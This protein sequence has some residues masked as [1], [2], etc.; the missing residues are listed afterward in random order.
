MTFTF[1][2]ETIELNNSNT[3]LKCRSKG[4]IVEV[5]ELLE[6][7]KNRQP[8]KVG[9]R[10]SVK[11]DCMASQDGTYVHIGCLKEPI[12]TYNKMYI[13]LVKHLNSTK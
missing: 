2:G 3:R 10:P 6:F 9:F 8:R 7:S 11:E 1:G 12:T 4:V 5:E 13:Q